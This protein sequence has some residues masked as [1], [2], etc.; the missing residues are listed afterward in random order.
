MKFVLI[1]FSS[2]I[3]SVGYSQQF[4]IGA[5]ISSIATTCN[6]SDVSYGAT[7]EY[8]PKNALFSVNSDPFVFRNSEHKSIV[9]LPLS[10]R[11]IMGNSIR[12]RPNLGLLVRSDINY[13]AFVGLSIEGNL[14]EQLIL[15]VKGDYVKNSYR[16]TIP[17]KFGGTDDE[18]LAWRKGYMYSLGIKKIIFRKSAEASTN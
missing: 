12:I 11:F 13:G 16:E 18:Y 17:N 1:V 9:T 2:L 8:Q 7:I 5:S 14:N 4:N 3:F 6:L 15:F 10:I